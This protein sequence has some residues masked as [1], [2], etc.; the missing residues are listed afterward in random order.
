MIDIKTWTFYCYILISYVTL[1][2]PAEEKGTI[3]VLKAELDRFSEELMK[4]R[5]EGWRQMGHVSR[6]QEPQTD[7]YQTVSSLV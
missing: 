5:G 6:E 3:R 7:W 2:P 1:V 4:L